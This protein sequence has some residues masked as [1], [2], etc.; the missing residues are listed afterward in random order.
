M[1]QRLYKSPDSL[2][3]TALTSFADLELPFRFHFLPIWIQ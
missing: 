1:P 2:V 3:M